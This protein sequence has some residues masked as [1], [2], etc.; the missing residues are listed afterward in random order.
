MRDLPSFFSLWN[1]YPTR[2][3]EGAVDSDELFR[4]IGGKVAAISPTNTCCIRLSLTL[5]RCGHPI[6]RAFK[7]VSTIPG[8]RNGEWYIPKLSHMITYLTHAYFKPKIDHSTRGFR[9][10]PDGFRQRG[11]IAFWW[12]YTGDSSTGH[13]DL[14]DGSHR[15]GVKYLVP[16][17]DPK[18]VKTKTLP[19]IDEGHLVDQY[20]TDATK[21]YLWPAVSALKCCRPDSHRRLESIAR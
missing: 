4:A 14:W 10:P 20:W 2:F 3:G 5:I 11:I 8:E 19:S 1:N 15:A 13:I 21:L 9:K 12:G 18:R 7:G 16:P 17:G 6:P